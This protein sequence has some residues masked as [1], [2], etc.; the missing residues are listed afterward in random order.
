MKNKIELPPITYE[1]YNSKLID[2]HKYKLPELKAACKEYRLKVTGNKPILKERIIE[3]FNKTT[4][5]ICIQKYIRRKFVILWMKQ[6]GPA[7]KKRNL[8]NNTTDFVT[9]E[10]I[11]DIPFIH[12]FT[13]KD[14]NNFIY[15]YDIASVVCSIFVHGKTK[16]PYTR[17]K[18][19]KRFTEKVNK[20]FNITC[21]LYPTF[22]KENENTYYKLNKMLRNYQRSNSSNSLFRY[23]APRTPR[24]ILL[25]RAR[26]DNH[27]R[28][29]LDNYEYRPHFNPNAFHND[30]NHELTTN[31]VRVNDLRRGSLNER[32]EN[33]FI[34]IDLLGNYT[35]S[36]WFT[37]L[38]YNQYVRFFRY[39]GDI[40]NFR[41]NMTTRTKLN[42]CPYYNPFDGVFPSG[43]E[44]TLDVVKLGCLIVF[45]NFVYCGINQEYRKIG[46]LHA[47]SALTLVSNPAREAMT[48]LYDSVR[49]T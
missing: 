49:F 8:C 7:I 44:I 38:N 42:I 30:G 41:S 31:W 32:I 15:G 45:E 9:M 5:C 18:F 21:I 14:H 20:L 37:T 27:I 40:W 43:A 13:Y 23:G 48:W 34:E 25:D 24:R 2:I 47:L 39:L 3:L 1:N 46:A 35:Q 6:K 10:P 17:E 4:S 16:N 33:L 11:E 36:S 28:I 29:T 26:E 19:S 22:K 12:L